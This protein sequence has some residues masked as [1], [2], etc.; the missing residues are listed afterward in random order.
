VSYAGRS[1][2]V[3]GAA[4]GIGAAIVEA[5]LEAGARVTA[6]DVDEAKLAELA[7]RLG[8]GEL[9]T[10][11]CDVGDDEQA[12]AAVA[13]HVARYDGLDVLFN[14]AGIMDDYAPVSELDDEQ[15]RRVMH[16]NVDGAMRM[17]RAAVGV[18]I[19]AGGGS[20]VNTA[21]AA[22]L[23]GG[24]AGAAYTISKHA[25]VGLTRSIA[26]M[27]A[28]DGI[29]CNALCPG[30]TDTGLGWRM[31]SNKTGLEA[32]KP[33]FS[34]VPDATTPQRMAGVALFLGSDEA[35]D[36]TGEILLA[37]RGWLVA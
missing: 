27:H 2:L 32:L 3:T 16:V 22:A 36:V 6:C 26:F 19:G 10:V 25:T 7:E 20:I 12:R 13:G 30:N 29:R 35:S 8:D 17:A 34:T 9:D 24:R 1:A 15:Y 33:V 31:R 23:R 28:A 14:N 37:D 21:S 11:V 18:M 5:L 4:S